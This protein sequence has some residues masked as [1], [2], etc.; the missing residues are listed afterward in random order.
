MNPTNDTGVPADPKSATPIRKYG[1]R[2]SLWGYALMA[3]MAMFLA[4][5]CI[6]S[7]S[8]LHAMGVNIWSMLA[9]SLFFASFW[10]LGM[11]FIRWINKE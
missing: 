5:A 9:S 3:F 11:T 6:K 2:I 8:R 4:L 10:A 7:F 1:I